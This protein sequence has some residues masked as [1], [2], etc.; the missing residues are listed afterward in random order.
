MD[1]LPFTNENGNLPLILLKYGFDR[2][3]ILEIR[4]TLLKE[5]KRQNEEDYDGN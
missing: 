4:D 3:D 1:N 5:I 2:E